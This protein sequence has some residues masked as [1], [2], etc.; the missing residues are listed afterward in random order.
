MYINIAMITLYIMVDP[1]KANK[2]KIGITKN[3]KQRLTTYRTASPQC[4]FYS[5]FP[6][7][8][9]KHEKQIIDIIREAFRVDREY[10]HC[11]P[12]IVKNIVEGYLNDLH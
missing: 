2:C 9:K 4:F 11:N 3:P 1:D 10:I 5:T 7:P 6:I 12:S 8:A